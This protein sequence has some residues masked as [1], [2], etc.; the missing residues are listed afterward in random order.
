MVNH[1]SNR[2]S[3][4]KRLA[5]ALLQKKF[6]F[7]QNQI[8]EG[9]EVDFWFP[10]YGLIIEVDGYH[11]LS[12]RQQLSDQQKDQRLI[13]KGLIVYRLNNQLIYEDLKQC[14]TEIEIIIKRI[15]MLL[16]EERTINDQWKEKLSKLKPVATKL[17]RKI[18]TIEDYFLNIDE[19][20]D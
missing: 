11:H 2:T 19:E 5:K 3:A 14:L 6:I 20:S 4:E 18:K 10:E 13:S 15:K 9:Y 12:E 1:N 17:P 7:K 16:N 8:I